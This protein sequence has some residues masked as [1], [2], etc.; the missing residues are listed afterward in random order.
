MEELTV[1]KNTVKLAIGMEHF[2]RKLIVEPPAEDQ[3]AHQAEE[4][5]KTLKS[6]G[7]L[8]YA[9]AFVRDALAELKGKKAAQDGETL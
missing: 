7:V 9:P 2:L 6:K 3:V 4:I 1:A 5:E 8:T